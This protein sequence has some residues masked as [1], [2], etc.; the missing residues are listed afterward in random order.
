MPKN[1]IS[2][3]SLTY[4][5]IFESVRNV[6]RLTGC[7]RHIQQFRKIPDNPS[8][9]LNLCFLCVLP[10]LIK[11]SPFNPFMK[12]STDR[13]HLGGSSCLGLCLFFR[14][15]RP[16]LIGVD[17]FRDQI[18]VFAG[19]LSSRLQANVGIAPIPAHNSAKRLAP[20]AQ[21]PIGE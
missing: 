4:P 19:K 14:R 6:L 11:R 10:A 17:T 21:N 1:A 5:Y 2:R 20:D 13:K 16:R 15:L 12:N 7:E 3:G 9:F 18:I 8:F